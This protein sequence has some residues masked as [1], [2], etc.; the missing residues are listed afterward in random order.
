MKMASGVIFKHTANEKL[1][2]TSPRDRHQARLRKL[3]RPTT[4]LMCFD[5]DRVNGRRLP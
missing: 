1:A 2:T 5:S 4:K 3:G